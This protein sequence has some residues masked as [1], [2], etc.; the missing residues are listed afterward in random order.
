MNQIAVISDVHGN[1][2]AL[3]AVLQDVQQRGITRILCLGDLVG[4]GPN[5][6]QVVD[7]L[8]EVCEIIIRG[9]WDESVLTPSQNQ[10]V[11]WQRRQLGQARLDYLA[12]LPTTIELLMSGKHIRLFHASAIGIYHRVQM[13]D[14]VEAH[15]G[16]FANTAFTGDAITP[17]VVGYGD[18][19]SMYLKTMRQRILFNAGSVGNPLDLTQAAYAILE[20]VSES[21]DPAPFTIRL[22][23]V[24]YDIERAIR[25][26]EDA[27]MPDLLP[28]VQ[29]LRTARYRNLPPVDDQIDLA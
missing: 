17:D 14:T 27:Q 16:M 23:R 20:G 28:Y 15:H 3:E 25:D 5:A 24:P 12:T 19:H 29:E 22:I 6:A 18:I 2:P 11:V 9:N 13:N 21:R 1:L 10:H 8:R 26:A 7:W 4:K